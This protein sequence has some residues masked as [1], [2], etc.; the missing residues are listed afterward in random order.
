MIFS[1]STRI[2]NSI[3][4]QILIKIS[5]LNYFPSNNAISMSILLAVSNLRIDF[6]IFNMNYLA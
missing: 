4:T 6:Y 1:S 5:R 2:V 3:K